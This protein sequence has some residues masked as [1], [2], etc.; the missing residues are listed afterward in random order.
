MALNDF[1]AKIEETFSEKSRIYQHGK[2]SFAH[3]NLFNILK[4]PCAK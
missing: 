3:C 1:Y 4:V 2:R